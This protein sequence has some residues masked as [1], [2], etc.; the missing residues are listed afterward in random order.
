MKGEVGGASTQ[1]FMLE[2]V[3]P[4]GW[5][6]GA[7]AHLE[8]LWW[9]PCRELRQDGWA[10][11]VESTL[12]IPVSLGLSRHPEKSGREDARGRVGFLLQ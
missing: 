2:E 8:G 3:D 7:P 4:C 6:K 5:Q 1:E 12:A 11:R 9:L 10:G